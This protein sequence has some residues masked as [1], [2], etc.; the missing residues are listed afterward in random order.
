MMNLAK[1]EDDL[2][3]IPKKKDRAVEKDT[4]FPD[5]INVAGDSVDQDRSLEEANTILAENEIGQQN[6]NL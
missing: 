2:T 4:I 1:K 6:E 5:F 3:T